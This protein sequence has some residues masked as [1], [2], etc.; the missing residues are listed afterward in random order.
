MIRLAI[1]VVLLVGRAALAQAEVQP[2]QRPG[3]SADIAA[4]VQ[5]LESRIDEMRS[6]FLNGDSESLDRALEMAQ[7]VYAVRQTQQTGWT[8][9]DQ[10]PQEWF[11]VSD[12]RR[13][14]EGLQ[15][16]AAL[17]IEDRAVLVEVE[18]VLEGEAQAA[19]A[20]GDHAGSTI[21]LG[22][23][24]EK[25]KRVLGDEHPWTLNR[26][27]TMGAVLYDAGRLSEAERYLRESVEGKRR[28]LGDDHPD[29][30]SS[31]NN[32]G[33]LLKDQG[34]LSEAEPNLRDA[35]E[36]RRWVF[37]DN[38]PSTLGS[39]NNIGLLL[40]TQ[41]RLSE[42][43]PYYRQALEG[44]RR[45]LGDNHPSTLSSINNLGFLLKAAGKL[46]EA[47]PY[48]REAMDGSRRLLGDDHPTTL[49]SISNMGLLLWA[50]GHL[51][52]AEVYY[53]EAMDGHRRVLGDNHPLTLRSIN[54]MGALR[55][56]QGRL[57]EAEPYRREALEGRRRVLG[58][59]N[60]MTLGSI[61]AMG[62]LLLAQGK[63]S[64]VEPFH[65]E[66]L[67]GRRR[68]LGNDHPMTLSSINS[69]GVLLQAQA[70]LAEAERYYREALV[71]AQRLRASASGGERGR[72]AMAGEVGLR[73]IVTNLSNL[74]ARRGAFDEGWTT[75]ELGRGRALL[76]LLSRSDQAIESQLADTTELIEARNA[77]TQARVR[78]VE[79]EAR[80]AALNKVRSRIESDT[81]L[82][83]TSRLDRL[84]E[85]DGQLEVQSDSILLARRDLGEATASVFHALQQVMPDAQTM[86][87]QQIQESLEVGDLI[88]GYIWSGD[89]VLL[90]TATRA[91][92]DG[93]F[94]AD[95][96]DEV[97]ALAE[98]VLHAR[99]ALAA[100]PNQAV[101]APRAGAELLRT[102]LPTAVRTQ[103]A[104]AARV[105][106]LPDGPL[107]GIPLEALDNVD[108]PILDDGT[109]QIVYASSATVYLNRRELGRSKS[110]L[111]SGSVVALGGAN[112]D[113]DRG[114]MDEE[115][116]LMAMLS[117]GERF[118]T[119]TVSALD[120]VRLHGETLSPL[121]FSRAE[122]MAVS[123]LA[124][125][126]GMTGSMLVG[127][128]A[129]IEKLE[130]SVDNARYLH[131][132]THGLVG[133]Q[134]RP[135]D[136][137]LALTQ[138]K[139]P[140]ANDIGFLTLDHLIRTW[141]GKLDTCDLV[142]LSAC[143]TQRGI[144][145][146]DAL[147]SLPWGFYYAGAPTV[148]AS[149]WQVDDEA[150]AKLMT[151]FYGNLFG[152]HDDVRTLRGEM[153]GPGEPMP[154][155]DALQ[156]AKR[157]LRTLET[158]TDRGVSR[159]ISTG[160]RPSRPYEHPY[161]WAA[162]VLTG[163]PG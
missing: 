1:A 138:P 85:L 54:N 106:I 143:D 5:Q 128:D 73:Q 23:I 33:I 9:R 63:L 43:E 65:R 51:P 37:G 80:R 10:N 81:S 71:I 135:Y 132:A 86:T 15:A 109:R 31:I 151:R 120:Q 139:E 130:S 146:G 113:P 87:I 53:R 46:S 45:V 64:E 18:A 74:L 72:A 105:I 137:S 158:T 42:A 69:M 161:Y 61:Q 62:G 38:H 119:A 16:L 101:H 145:Q 20:R 152:S 39:I 76:D 21:L 40:H 111:E 114:E 67:E 36:A 24:I 58:N 127:E 154:K 48:S 98:S 147:M 155:A 32:L 163:D 110:L 95:S 97:A 41:G 116:M 8:D 117:R 30:L 4:E 6:A 89:S 150:T 131:L 144:R 47:E 79:A 27:N 123:V 108:E 121:P 92:V 149:L 125:Q 59:D 88:V 90:L 140:T 17:S 94:V 134:D 13:R 82:D 136:A 78:M 100:R 99:R 11:E 77:E 156:E 84:A 96:E 68:I 52:E 34:K 50:Q 142:V 60:P 3:L 93:E 102:L 157:W 19:H 12:A 25:L 129:T 141:R 44:K 148:V 26:I 35:L 133:T 29:T 122:A 75:T 28:A 104:A 2:P 56:A 14:V 107:A 160:A 126:A 7:R 153:Y 57:S 49:H 22:Q 162:F 124:R 118:A 91:S 103:V 66:A 55:E 159:A 83:D 70:K 115:A 112:L